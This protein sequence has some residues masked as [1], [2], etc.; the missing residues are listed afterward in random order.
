ML[1]MRVPTAVGRGRPSPLPRTVSVT[2]TRSPARDEAGSVIAHPL[3]HVCAASFLLLSASFP[4]HS[5]AAIETYTLRPIED[6]AKVVPK[7]AKPKLEDQLERL[8]R[9][10]GYKVRVLTQYTDTSGGR[11][12]ANIPTASELKVGWDI[13]D[14]LND[15]YAIIFMD[16]SAPNVLGFKYSKTVQ[17]EKLPRPFFTELQSR[18]GNMFYVRDNGEYRALKESIDAL[19]VCFRKPDGC[20]VPPGL[21]EEQYFFTLLCCVLGGGILGSSLRIDPVGFVR[22]RWVY[23]ALFSPLWAT[24][25]ISY[26]LGPIV[27]RTDDVLP[28]IVNVGATIASAALIANYKKAA[29]AVGLTVSQTIDDE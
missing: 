8:E 10:T 11:Q 23:G 27:S 21:P 4:P 20:Q 1:S 25:S 15:N 22:R 16:P 9:D 19:D 5:R 2:A 29:D 14:D 13:K 26:G 28:V 12:N 3:A 18:Y 17:T 7:D 6:Y 24:L